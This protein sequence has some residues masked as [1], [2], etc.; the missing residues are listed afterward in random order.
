MSENRSC[1][2]GRRFFRKLLVIVF[3]ILLIFIFVNRVAILPAQAFSKPSNSEFFRIQ[4]NNGC[5]LFGLI[6]WGGRPSRTNNGRPARTD[7]AIRRGKCNSLEP[8][9][10][11]LVPLAWSPPSL[12][13]ETDWPTSVSMVEGHTIDKYPTFWVFIPSI[14]NR[15]KE[16]EHYADY[17]EIMVQNDKGQDVLIDAPIRITLPKDQ[18]FLGLRVL[19]QPLE[20]DTPYYWYFSVICDPDRPSRNPSVDG[21]VWVLP[22]EEVQF[23]ES[24]L[25]LTSPRL[26]QKIQEYTGAGLWYDALTL[27]AQERCA[28]PENT[29]L[30]DAWKAL[31]EAG[32]VLSNSDEVRLRSSPIIGLIEM[33]SNGEVTNICDS[34]NPNSHQRQSPTK[35]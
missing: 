4:S 10:T 26:E 16:N 20:V 19:S 9:L 30:V 34:S 14:L 6:C 12:L 13:K 28:D 24:N 32:E 11:S 3:S 29:E 21:I 7:S 1:W 2:K 35:T 25:T 27:L 17:A 15:N 31:L 23:E 22:N 18:G 33:Q 5:T 8:P